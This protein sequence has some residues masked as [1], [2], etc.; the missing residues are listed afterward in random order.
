MKEGK[1][2]RSKSGKVQ[3]NVLKKKLTKFSVREFLYFLRDLWNIFKGKQNTR[4]R[5]KN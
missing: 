5:K 1:K 3:I 4:T 2:T